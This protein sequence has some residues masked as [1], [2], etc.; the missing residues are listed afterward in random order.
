MAINP[1]LLPNAAPQ[2]IPFVLAST[3]LLAQAL[4][5]ANERLVRHFPA[6]GW[7]TWGDTLRQ[8]QPDLLVR[9]QVVTFDWQDLAHRVQGLATFPEMPALDAPTDEPTVAGLAEQFRAYQQQA[10]LAL[11]ELQDNPRAPGPLVYA[12][13]TQLA[14]SSATAQQGYD[15][16][17]GAG[18]QPATHPRPLAFE[19][20]LPSLGPAEGIAERREAGR[21]S[22]DL[23]PSLPLLPQMNLP[24]RALR[25]NALT[26]RTFRDIIQQHPRSNGK[27]G[28]TVR[29]LCTTMHISAASLTKARNN[30]GRLSLNAVVALAEAMNECPLDVIMDLLA[31]AGAKK[32]RNRKTGNAASTAGA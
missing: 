23:V 17:K 2:R 28:F 25:R 21:E 13:V 4:T 6:L 32:K 30:P 11:A 16:T 9:G 20:P 15:A 7:A 18:L 1:L 26:R 12:L 14:Q 22:A 8:L 3:L 5:D 27:F 29:E 10:V 19:Q 31:E 24:N